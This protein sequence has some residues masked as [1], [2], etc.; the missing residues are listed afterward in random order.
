VTEGPP[1]ARGIP[2]P[3]ATHEPL[4]EL[5]HFAFAQAPRLCRPE[6][7]CGIYHQAWSAMRLF[8]QDGASPPGSAFIGRELQR[9]RKG[10]RVLISG[11]ADTGL[12]AMVDA[13]LPDDGRAR[14]VLAERCETPLTQNRQFARLLGR[15]V[16]FHLGD[17]LALRCAPVDAIL[18]HSFLVHFDAVAQRAVIAKWAELLLPGG[19]LLLSN[20]LAPAHRPPRERVP[21]EANAA[22]LPGIL[23]RARAAGWSATECETL[24]TLARQF[25]NLPASHTITEHQL[26]SDLAQAG[27]EVLALDFDDDAAPTGPAS[28]RNVASGYRRAEIVARKP[29]VATAP[30]VRPR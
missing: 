23:D 26:R 30:G 2:A 13:A 6:H 9:L 12:M 28:R 1:S 14:L 16:E 11:S 21:V 18:A 29:P 7:G 15:E 8:D 22:R 17:I 24:A 27:L 4:T 19:V 25:W 3:P 20:R 5:A 10:A